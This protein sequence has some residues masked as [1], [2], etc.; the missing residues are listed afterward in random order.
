MS[1]RNSSPTLVGRNVTV[2][3]Q[4]FAIVVTAAGLKAAVQAGIGRGWVPSAALQSTLLTQAQAVIDAVA[5]NGNQASNRLNA[6]S[7]TV[8]FA[9]STQ[10]TA[11]FKS[12]LLN[13]ASDLGT[14]V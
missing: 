12:L 7:T 4:W 6:F 3:T 5:K 2:A 1:S 10:L 11:A 14:R 8:L 9:S 13:W